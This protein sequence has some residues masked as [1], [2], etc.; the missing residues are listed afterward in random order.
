MS[1][2]VV[3]TGDMNIVMGPNSGRVVISGYDW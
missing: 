1:V 2:S 3:N